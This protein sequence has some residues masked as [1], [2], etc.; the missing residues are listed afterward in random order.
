MT[1]EGRLPAAAEPAAGTTK[2]T[3]IRWA[4]AATLVTA[5]AVAIVVGT[6][7]GGGADDTPEVAAASAT[8]Q[9]PSGGTPST[10]AFDLAP[11]DVTNVT[12]EA[13]ATGS[14][15]TP[16][17]AATTSGPPATPAPTPMTWQQQV[18]T[19]PDAPLRLNPLASDW[20]VEQLVIGKDVA[21]K[22]LGRVAIRY[23]GPGSASGTFAI[24]LVKDGREIARLVGQ[25][26]GDVRAGLYPVILATDASYVDG[27]W[28][29]QFRVTSTA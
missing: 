23:S 17:P 24:V 12:T 20:T 2:V 10:P 1:N 4:A 21:G 7:M 6:T 8:D 13:A 3:A 25:T 27:P 29:T 14:P 28:T 9:P 22:F 26:A 11:R 16:P 5:L 19:Q 15:G 18:A